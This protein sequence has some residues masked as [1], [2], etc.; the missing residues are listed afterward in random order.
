MR[1][2]YALGVG[3]CAGGIEQGSE[4]AIVRGRRGEVSRA[5]FKDGRHVAEPAFFFP[6]AGCAIRVG[7]DHSQFQF[8]G[9]RPSDRDVLR[10]AED[11]GGAAVFQ[12]LG[13]LVVVQSGI[14]RNGG[15]TGGDDS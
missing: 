5:G 9:G 8:G 15:A 13:D 6:I 4:I 3:G 2:H 14:E 1:E 10:I 11:R 7:E 12:Q